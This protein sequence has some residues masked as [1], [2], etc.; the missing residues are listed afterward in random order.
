[1]LNKY[2]IKYTISKYTNKDYI[3]KCGKGFGGGECGILRE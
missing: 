2:T 3:C 1:M